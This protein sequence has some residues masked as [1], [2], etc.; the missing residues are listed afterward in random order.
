[1]SLAERIRRTRDVR[2]LW[3]AHHLPKRILFWAY[4]YAGSSAM[5]KDTVVPEA[6]FTELLK[7]MPG[8]PHA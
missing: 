8:Q 3:I 2:N 7:T 1:M 5:N 6:N 4:V